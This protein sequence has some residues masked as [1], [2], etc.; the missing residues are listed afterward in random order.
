[1]SQLLETLEELDNLS[2]QAKA[3]RA[4]VSTL[5]PDNSVMQG[6]MR[7]LSERLPKFVYF[8]NYFRLPG[9]V[10]LTD[11][12]RREQEESLEFE[13]RVFL[14]LL[15]H[16][17]T[18]VQNLQQSGTFERLVARLEGIAN[19]IGGQIFEYWSQ[20]RHLEVQF[21]LGPGLP[22]DPAP[23]NEGDVFR[24]R[25]RNARHRV[26]VDFDERSTGFVWFFSFL[27]WFSELQRA[28]GD[29]LIIL[30]DEPGLSL[31]A[32]A[33]ADLLRYFNEQLRPRYQL[34]YTTHSPFMVDPD[35]LTSVRTVEDVGTDDVVG[36]RVGDR[37]LSTDADTLFP[38]QAALG[39]DITQSLFVGRHT[40]LVEG[41]SDLLY[42][43][44]F[45]R[46]LQE[47]KRASLDQHWIIAP[48]GGADK[49]NAFT[50]LFAG[51]HLNIAVLLDYAEGQKGK[52]RALREL[53]V[54][55]Q[56]RVLTAEVY[57]GQAEAD[58][59][60]IL[61]RALYIDLVARTFKLKNAQ[62]LLAVRPATA[63]ER[64]VK[65]VEEHFRTLPTTVDNFDH[66]APALH[67]L[68]HTSTLRTQLAGL[69]DALDRFEKLFQDLNALLPR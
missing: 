29:R 41:P 35:R 69:D 59:E 51:N 3:L 10:S 8:A 7:V 63:S 55:R 21:F 44:W 12:A 52:I 31:H 22:K 14:A 4:H 57:A 48:I 60:D 28:Y 11:L 9:K 25:I 38:L 23:F 61:G 18:S 43:N 49:V 64:V 56:G 66:Y 46:E 67:L 27:I 15:N 36:T 45:R 53:E 13:D 16:A 47:R 37:V 40:L 5:A 33:Q 2:E 20:N 1:V 32:K 34:I 42:I 62:K 30:L 68:E 58:V 65:E 50:A 24:T 6:A 39:Y 17:G 54:L 26:T 19:R